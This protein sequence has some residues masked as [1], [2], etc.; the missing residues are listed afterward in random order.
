MNK[1]C[2][3][4][5]A[6]LIILTSVF[7]GYADASELTP[8]AKKLLKGRTVQVDFG[9]PPY[10]DRSAASIADEISVNG[11]EGVY[12]FVVSD[13]AT[14]K[15]II[16][17]LQK[18]GIPVAVMVIASGAYLPVNERPA[19]WE[20][21]RM[22]FTNNVL[23]IYQLISY[24]HKDY[25]VW[26]KHRVV[27]LIKKYGI[28]G[29][30]FAEAMY[31]IADGLEQTNV[32][33]GDISPAFQAAFKNDTG[34]SVFPEFV[35]KS[36]PNYYK[37]IPKV[38]KALIEYRIKT[39]NDFYNEVINGAGGVRE[40]CPGVFVATWTMAIN[41]PNGDKKLREWEGNDTPSMI[42]K[43]KP[44]MHFIQTHAPDWSNPALKGDYPKLYKPFFDLV[45]K[46]DP[47]MPIGFQADFVSNENIRRNPKWV[48]LFY[49]TCDQMWL[50]CTTYYEFGLRWNIYHEPPRLCKVRQVWKNEIVLSF[51]QRIS[52]DCENIVVGR[53]MIISDYGRGYN[54]KQ[55]DVDGNL[56]KLILDQDIS[57][58]RQVTLQLGGIKDDP[59]YRYERPGG[60]QIMLKGEVNV[61]QD[62]FSKTM[63]IE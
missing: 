61:V 56:L 62:G 45:K 4:A 1:M 27:N 38:Y 58:E 43:I 12:Y 9:F 3:F 46:T 20:K 21:W 39:V 40:K 55:A 34:N 30:T 32:L 53:K 54:V 24:V 37:K 7:G 51:D 18:R 29:F 5:L 60:G 31:P 36:K 13:I 19:D 57:G 50:E 8:M 63:L 42:R 26:M 23:D 14:R 10:K 33:Y 48:E 52:K 16:V 15:D 59:A 28:D 25:A 49:K 22:Q 41:L 17:E 47:K 35:D 6:L 11:Y 44:D 2:I